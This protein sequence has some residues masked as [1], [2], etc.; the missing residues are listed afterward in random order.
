MMKG[1]EYQSDFAKKY[2]AQGRDEGRTEGRD[3]GRT[4]GR[5][6][7]EAQ[8][9]LT[10]LRGRGIAVPDSE[11]A[12]ILAEKDSA[13]LLRWIEKALVTTSLMEVLEEPS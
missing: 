9:L 3:E 12:R 11:R 6:E 8:A 2:V 13:R 4:E 1:Y 10:V 7:G 5:V